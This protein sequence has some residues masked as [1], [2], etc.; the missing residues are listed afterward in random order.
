MAVSSRFAAIAAIAAVLAALTVTAVDAPAAFEGRACKDPVG[1]R[2]ADCRVGKH[3]I[4]DLSRQAYYA[5][6]DQ[7]VTISDRVYNLAPNPKARNDR[8]WP[9]IDS[10]GQRI[11]RVEYRSKRDIVLRGPTGLPY[12]V[13]SLRVRGRGCMASRTL[14]QRH[15]LLQVIAKAPPSG[16]T[17][18]FIDAAALNQRSATGLRAY[19]AWRDQRGGGT[20]CGPSGRTIGARRLLADPDVGRHARA[21]LSNGTINSVTEYDAKDLFGDIVYFNSNTTQVRAGG[22]ARG[23]VRVGTPIRKV[24]SFATCDPSSDGTLTWNYWAVETGR[25]DRPRLF[26]WIPARCPTR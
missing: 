1:Y 9:L 8:T 4:P 17:Q 16:G 13:T 6:R 23:M 21:R 12:K 18:G 11:G 19:R 14:E 7:E 3:G 5:L 2:I 24:D 10:L 22:I 26:G 25:R 20:G 15:A